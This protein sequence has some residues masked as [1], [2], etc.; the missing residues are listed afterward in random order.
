MTDLTPGQSLAISFASR[1]GKP[2]SPDWL[3]EVRQAL[4]RTTGVQLHIAE[5]LEMAHTFDVMVAGF[6]IM[7]EK[8]Q[9]HAVH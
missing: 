8:G 9:R 5:V 7:V 3:H 6:N 2:K 1:F 4:Q